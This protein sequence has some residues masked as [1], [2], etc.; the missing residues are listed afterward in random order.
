[1]SVEY[2]ACIALG[3]LVS[4]IEAYQMNLK[5]NFKYED[6]FIPI[7]QYSE[8]SHK[9]FGE[10][11]LEVNAGELDTFIIAD[12]FTSRSW[13]NEW[14]QKLIDCGREDLV[15]KNRQEFLICQVV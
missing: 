6:C 8:I 14:N 13:I 7:D 4:D 11:L 15:K 10:V 12:F 3:W 2:K 9:V 1:M 5:T